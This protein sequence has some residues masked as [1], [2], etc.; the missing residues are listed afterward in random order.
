[1]A[2]VLTAYIVM[3][4]ILMGYIVMGYVV[5]CRC[6]MAGLARR[7]GADVVVCA[8]VHVVVHTVVHVGKSRSATSRLWSAP[9]SRLN[10]D[11]LYRDGL[12]HGSGLHRSLA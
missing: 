2:Y 6:G 12:S 7:R 10:S 5:A 11:G 3:G 1:M 8:I 9:L 4:Y